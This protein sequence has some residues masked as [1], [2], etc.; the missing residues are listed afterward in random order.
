AAN[1]GKRTQTAAS[2]GRHEIV[3]CA[4]VALKSAAFVGLSARASSDSHP[5]RQ[6][7]NNLIGP[8]GFSR[9]M[10]CN[11]H[12][13]SRKIKRI[14][15]CLGHVGSISAPGCG[16][17]MCVRSFRFQRSSP[18]AT[19]PYTICSSSVHPTRRSMNDDVRVIGVI[20]GKVATAFQELVDAR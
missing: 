6:L 2:S 8:R 9:A 17:V 14:A 7:L 10:A 4:S 18:E 3:G 20:S 19:R 15:A 16:I 13:L 11:A 12:F 1:P 5:L